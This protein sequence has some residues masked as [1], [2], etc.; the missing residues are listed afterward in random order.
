MKKLALVFLV[1]IL[2]AS[3]VSCDKSQEPEIEVCTSD[4]VPYTYDEFMSAYGQNED[5][6][7]PKLMT[8]DFYC[9]RVNVN[10]SKNVFYYNPSYVSKD[11]YFAHSKGITVWV[12]LRENSYEEITKE[13]EGEYPQWIEHISDNYA[14]EKVTNMWYINFD[15]RCVTIYFPDDIQF[16]DPE[17]ISD[18][19]EFEILNPSNDN[20][21]TQ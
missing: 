6:I 21:V 2:I 17:R 1:F 4:V 14:Y 12:S 7:V 16:S 18:Y 20:T 10:N 11:S 19:F 8:D 3:F 15:G 9:T 13:E 5:I